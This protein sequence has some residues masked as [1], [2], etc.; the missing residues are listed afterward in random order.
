MKHMRMISRRPAKGA[1]FTVSDILALIGQIMT[2][3]ATFIVQK[4]AAEVEDY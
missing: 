1:N 2:V 4:E 3:V